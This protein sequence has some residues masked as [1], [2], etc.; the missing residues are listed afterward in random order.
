M[1]IAAAFGIA[2]PIIN[3]KLAKSKFFTFIPTA[4]SLGLA[5]IISPPQS[6]MLFFGTIAAL[7]WEK[8]SVANY[9]GFKQAMY[10]L[11]DHIIIAE[12]CNSLASGLIA[13]AGLC[14]VL[15]AVLQL[16]DVPTY[17][18]NAGY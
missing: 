10:S 11:S 4:S 14:G 6:L 8:V 17:D 2:L 13:G 9:K 16:L 3:R 1:L 18:P 5:F 7:I 12:F 15:N